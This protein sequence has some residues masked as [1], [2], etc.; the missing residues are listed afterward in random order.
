MGEVRQPH[1]LIM[2][3][4]INTG[5]NQ[6]ALVETGEHGDRNHLGAIGRS[7]LGILHHRAPAAG[8]D[9]NDCGFGHM[10]RLH[11]RRDGVGDVMQFQV[12]KDRQSD[13]RDFVHPMVAVGTE[14]FQAQLD[15]TNMGFYAG[16]QRLGRFQTRQVKREIDRI[17]HTGF[18]GV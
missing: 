1:D 6:V 9:G 16:G 14:E 18:F 7:G 2:R 8:V 17:A 5:A 11:R 3:A 4:A 13:L 10:D 15:P 12:Q